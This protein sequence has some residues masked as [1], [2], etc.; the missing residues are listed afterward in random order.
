MCFSRFVVDGEG[1]GDE[2]DDGD[3]DENDDG[4]GDGDENDYGDG[5]ENDYGGGEYGEC[6]F[7]C[8][9]VS[10]VKRRVVMVGE[11]VGEITPMR[12]R[13]TNLRVL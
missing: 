13:H 1:D 12:V 3:G 9:R 8:E 7:D 11:I 10:G 4:D 6:N 2:N 5:D